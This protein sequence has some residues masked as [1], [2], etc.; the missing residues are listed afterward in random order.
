MKINFKT[1][2]HDSHRYSTVG[3]YFK[4]EDNTWKFRVSKMKNEDYEF[5]VFIHELTEWYLT[6]KRGITEKSITEFDKE[7]EK[8]REYFPKI[9]GDQE[10]GHMV[11]A[12]YHKEHVFA[13]K[14]EKLVAEELGVDWKKYDDTVNSL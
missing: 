14:I 3:D 9:I 11:S 10:P 12:P 5:L 7:F 1:I 8:V 4:G 13:E 2:S 6:Q